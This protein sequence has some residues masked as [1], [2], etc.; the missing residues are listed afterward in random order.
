MFIRDY[1]VQLAEPL[2]LF[3]L[4]I[5]IVATPFITFELSKGQ[6]AILTGALGVAWGYSM[7]DFVILFWSHE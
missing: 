1:G 7:V 5:T 4:L 2:L 3:G 6:Y